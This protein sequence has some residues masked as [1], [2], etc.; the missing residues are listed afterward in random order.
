MNSRDKTAR[1]IKE[2][3]IQ[4][5]LTQDD[6]AKLLEV[7]RQQVGKYENS[8]CELPADSAGKLAKKFNVSVDYIVGLTDDPITV[9][10][11]KQQV[12]SLSMSPEL[13]AMWQRIKD[14][15][16]LQQLILQASK[17]GA[18]AI[19]ALLPLIEV[20]ED[21]VFPTK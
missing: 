12:S 14:R 17:K 18:N 16:D 2:L 7:T 1:R 13:M 15:P 19:L 3:R 20:I 21:Q 8:K 9:D 10:E 4:N 11:Y 5:G 6:I